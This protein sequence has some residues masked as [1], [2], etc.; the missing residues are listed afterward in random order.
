MRHT[1]SFNVDDRKHFFV[2]CLRPGPPPP[3]FMVLSGCDRSAV[4][5]YVGWINTMFSV[6]NEVTLP[7]TITSQNSD[8]LF[9]FPSGAS[10]ALLFC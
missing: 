4:L 10:Q 3:P 8:F 2:R 7:R 1:H 6:S 9:I 5:V